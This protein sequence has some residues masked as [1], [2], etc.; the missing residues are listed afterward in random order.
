MNLTDQ[1]FEQEIA[2]EEKSVLVDFYANWCGP[3]KILGPVLKKV[4]EEMNDKII[5]E[6]INVDEFPQT[7]QKFRIDR[8]PMVIL[9]SKGKAIDGFVGAMPEQAIKQWIEEAFK[10]YEIKT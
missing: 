1:N 6:K 9:F 8:I 10:K 4:I 5:L 2:K 7:S 3:C